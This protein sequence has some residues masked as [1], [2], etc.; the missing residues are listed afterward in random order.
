MRMRR[1]EEGREKED[2]I[3]FVFTVSKQLRR[4]W[5]LPR[6]WEASNCNFARETL[7]LTCGFSFSVFGWSA[8]LLLTV[9][10]ALTLLCFLLFVWVWLLFCSDTATPTPSLAPDDDLVLRPPPPDFCCVLIA[11]RLLI[12]RRFYGDAS[13]SFFSLVFKGVYLCYIHNTRQKNCI[14]TRNSVCGDKKKEEKKLYYWVLFKEITRSLFGM[15][16]CI[17]GAAL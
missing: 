2:V 15:F 8:V 9:S 4:W 11:L 12:V 6:Q 10:L 16:V 13:W 1:R 5:K 17:G 7:T 3:R 14:F